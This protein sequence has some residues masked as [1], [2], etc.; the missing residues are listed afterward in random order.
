MKSEIFAWPNCG[1][2]IESPKI[3]AARAFVR[4][5]HVFGHQVTAM[6]D[7]LIRTLSPVW[8]RLQIG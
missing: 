6:G 2:S 1:A 7:K 5:K 4:I 8:T 3:V